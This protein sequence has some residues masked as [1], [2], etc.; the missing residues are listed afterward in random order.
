[1]E[2]WR[3]QIQRNFG[4]GNSD[5][6]EKWSGETSLDEQLR[7]VTQRAHDLSSGIK[8][9]RDELNILQAVGKYQ[10]DIQE[11]L[12]MRP[13]RVH[14]SQGLP[15]S[16]AKEPLTDPTQRLQPNVDAAY[17]VNDIREM[18]LVADRIQASVSILQSL[19][20]KSS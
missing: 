4:Q 19:N 12:Y 9:I 2:R 20:V 15:G 1:M 18:D 3:N 14:E 16:S 17:V 6:G 7:R 5:S 10:K 11:A 8:D 13:A